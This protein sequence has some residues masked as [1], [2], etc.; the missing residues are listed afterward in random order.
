MATST[1]DPD[2]LPSV[3]GQLIQRR[4]GESTSAKDSRSPPESCDSE[5]ELD[6][7]TESEAEPAERARAGRYGLR[8]KVVPPQKLVQVEVS[9]RD[10]QS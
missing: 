9:D 3:G 2:T 6:N 10:V 4:C 5:S 7:E 8:K 1:E